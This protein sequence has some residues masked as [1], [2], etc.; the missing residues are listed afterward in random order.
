MEIKLTADW[1]IMHDSEIFIDAEG[2]GCFRMFDDGLHYHLIELALR[3]IHVIYECDELY[4]EDDKEYKNP[5]YY[6]T[7]ENIEDLKSPCPELYAEYQRMINVK[8]KEAEEWKA[9][10]D[11]ILKFLDVPKTRNQIINHIEKEFYPK[12]DQNETSE[13]FIKAHVGYLIDSL[14]KKDLIRFEKGKIARM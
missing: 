8:I 4:D 3:T 11:L 1:I 12:D 9:K 13:N 5:T 2:K 7:F 10:Q 14:Y 6:Y